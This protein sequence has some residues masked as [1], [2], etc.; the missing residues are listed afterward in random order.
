MTG[1]HI[2]LH[3]YLNPR[4]RVTGISA[5]RPMSKWRRVLAWL[6]GR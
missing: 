3:N 6:V 1:L 5:Y 4:L 2:A